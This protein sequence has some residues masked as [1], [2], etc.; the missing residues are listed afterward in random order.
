MAKEKAEMGSATEERRTGGG[1]GGGRRL[2]RRD[3]RWM[4]GRASTPQGPAERGW[5]D[6]LSSPTIAGGVRIAGPR[7][8]RGEVLQY[9][10]HVAAAVCSC[11]NPARWL[12][13]GF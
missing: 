2:R 3:R 12:V 8:R 10:S 11:G 9:Q 7:L 1:W 13:A 6:G 5:A 4:C